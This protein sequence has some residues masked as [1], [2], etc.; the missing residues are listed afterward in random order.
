MPFPSSVDSFVMGRFS[1]NRH[2]FLFSEAGRMR[3]FW[4]KFQR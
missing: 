2:L 4:G 3:Q 1:R